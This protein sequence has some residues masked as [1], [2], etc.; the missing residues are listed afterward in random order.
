MPIKLYLCSAVKVAETKCEE[1]FR[2]S[3][4]KGEN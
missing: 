2:G 4:E 3:Y 1:T